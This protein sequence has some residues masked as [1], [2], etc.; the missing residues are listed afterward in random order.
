MDWLA[1]EDLLEEMTFEQRP[2]M[3]EGLSLAGI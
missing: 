3:S 1:Q 2:P